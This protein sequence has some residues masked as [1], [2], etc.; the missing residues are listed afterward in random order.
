MQGGAGPLGGRPNLAKQRFIFLIKKNKTECTRRRRKYENIDH[1]YSIEE[2]LH[3]CEFVL[4]C[5]KKNIKD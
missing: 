3:I 5:K 2:E 1:K 4:I